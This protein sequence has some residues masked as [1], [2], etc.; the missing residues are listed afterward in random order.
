MIVSILSGVIVFSILI[1]L[2]L[3]ILHFSGLDM[4]RGKTYSFLTAS[5]TKRPDVSKQYSALQ[6][7]CLALIFRIVIYIFEALILFMLTDEHFTFTTFL[8][9]LEIWDS[10]NYVRIAGGGY[11]SYTENGAYTTLVFFPLYPYAARL[12]NF[13]IQNLRVSLL[14]T[15][16]LAYA[17]GCVFLY[18]LCLCD[19]SHTAAKRSAIY[20]SIFPF[21]FFFGAMMSESML[22]FTT[23][24]ALYFIRK[25]KWFLAGLCGLLA[26]LSRLAGVVVIFAAAAE[27]LEEYKIVSLIQKREFKKILSVIFSKGLYLLLI[28]LGTVIYL[29][30]NKI[31]AGNYFAFLQYD[32]QFWGQGS[33]FI[34]KCI[35]MTAKNAF[36][37]A[38]VK[39]SLSMWLPYLII[40]IFGIVMI[41]YG[42]RRNRSMYSAYFLAYFILNTSVKYP[43]SGCRYMTCMI[44]MFMFLAD[45]TTRH[46]R[47]DAWITVTFSILFGIY[48]IAYFNSLII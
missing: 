17:G 47:A 38:N 27:F 10:T 16:T 18:K 39:R 1:W 5:L 43:I 22:F 19:Y 25:H 20:I 32:S 42:M 44:P 7:F 15:S 28:P 21:A 9:R 3:R 11:S 8:R 46:D 31:V 2:I 23:A 33:Q 37:F 35:S 26:S 12:I 24:M 13:V 34:G 14:M 48:L 29:I 40:I 6:V 41:I 30:V 36:D 45:F 4:P